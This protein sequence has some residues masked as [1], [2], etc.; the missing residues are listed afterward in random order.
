MAKRVRR[1]IKQEKHRQR[2]IL[3]EKKR[4]EKAGKSTTASRSSHAM[5]MAKRSKASKAAKAKRK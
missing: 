1:V 4:L 2:D 3:A 5:G